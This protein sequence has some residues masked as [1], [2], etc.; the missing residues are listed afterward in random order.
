MSGEPLAPPLGVVLREEGGERGERK[1]AGHR[2]LHRAGLKISKTY[3]ELE[4][5][6]DLRQVL[7]C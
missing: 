6:A 2:T 7:A 4:K 3:I 1:E 5:S